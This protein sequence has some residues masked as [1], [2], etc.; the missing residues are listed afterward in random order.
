MS[1][2][3]KIQSVSSV[4]E[5]ALS[6]TSDGCLMLF[7]FSNENGGPIVKTQFLGNA[8]ICSADLVK[9]L[10]TVEIQTTNVG[11]SEVDVTF[12]VSG[13]YE[14]RGPMTVKPS[15]LFTIRFRRDDVKGNSYTR[16]GGWKSGDG[17]LSK[18]NYFLT[19]GQW[20]R[21]PSEYYFRSGR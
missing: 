8:K 18:L 2:A 15:F 12:K 4:K 1:R 10:E 13:G 20:S 7:V 9:M 16:V 6:V 21:D 11:G 5:F 14:V 19:G 17:G 3:I